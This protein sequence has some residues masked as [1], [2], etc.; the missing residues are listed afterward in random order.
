MVY[1]LDP[2]RDGKILWE[3]ELAAGGP[4]GGIMWG[5]GPG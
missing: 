5:C 1:G 3:N 4:Q 2:D